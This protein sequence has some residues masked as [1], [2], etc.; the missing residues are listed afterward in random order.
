MKTLDALLYQ[1]VGEADESRIDTA[2]RE[3][4][5]AAFPALVRHVQHRTGWDM[6]SAEDL[7]QDALLRFFERVGRGRWE[8]AAFVRSESAQ[9]TALYFGVLHSRRVARWAGDVCAFADSTVNWRLPAGAVDATE[10]GRASAS[11][12]SAQIA[13]LQAGGRCLVDELRRML[14]W[15]L[16]QSSGQQA[17][18]PDSLPLESSEGM[19]SEVRDDDVARFARDLAR[20]RS[21]LT[22]R[23]AAIEERFPGAWRFVESIVTIIEWL[24][25][26]RVPTNG[27][28]FDIAT[29]TVLDEIKK[30]RRR[31]RGGVE[32]SANDYSAHEGGVRDGSVHPLDVIPDEASAGGE[33]DEWSRPEQV[34]GSCSGFAGM[35]PLAVD[36]TRGY[37]DLE[38]LQQFYEYLREPVARALRALDEAR[39]KGRAL[40]EQ[41]RFESVSRKFARTVT[42]LSMLG[43]GYTQ[44]EAAVLDCPAIR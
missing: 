33:A 43:E 18:Y 38:L 7:A 39:E 36:P 34:P 29:T 6:S 28:L 26:L 35:S 42:V 5:S 22:P 11:S 2:F 3:Y 25:R 37:E 15:P 16:E 32:H 1:W 27:Y 23:A 44:E 13:P 21:L 20:E 40:A 12:L 30:M 10:E 17:S 9:L 41:R 4:Y 19:A 8:A 14:K 31:K 24:P